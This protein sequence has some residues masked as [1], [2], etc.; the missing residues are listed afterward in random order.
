MQAR[1]CIHVAVRC[2]PLSSREK[3]DGAQSVVAAGKPM[4][5]GP[6]VIVLPASVSGVGRADE[7]P[8]RSMEA[9]EEGG[10]AMA[11]A[12][13]PAPWIQATIDTL[14]KLI[15]RP[16][17]TANLLTRPPFRFIHDVRIPPT[18]R[19]RAVPSRVRRAQAWGGHRGSACASA[20]AML[21]IILQV[22][23]VFSTRFLG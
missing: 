11:D 5:W 6:T 13:P 8:A 23:P 9:A 1:P 14:G 18:A 17:L 4:E 10:G 7:G 3:R 2:R 12:A 19:A 16:K 15:R 20:Q 21:I 22:H